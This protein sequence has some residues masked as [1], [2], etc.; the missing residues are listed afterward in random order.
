MRLV[1]LVG[2]LRRGAAFAVL[3]VALATLALSL[4]QCQMVEERLTGVSLDCAKPNQCVI[5]CTKVLVESTAREIHTHVVNVKTCHRD[6]VCLALENIRHVDALKL[7]AA[8][9][10]ACLAQC[11]HQGSGGGR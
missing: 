3:G 11:H 10:K 5:K 6:S 2:R 8:N 1:H 9:H 7:I 4:S